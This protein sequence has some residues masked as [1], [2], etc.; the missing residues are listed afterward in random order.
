M[1]NMH[2]DGATQ[3]I[4]VHVVWG[5]AYVRVHAYT[6]S[7]CAF[8]TILLTSLKVDVGILCLGDLA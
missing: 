5:Q 2:I 1:T 4:H 6:Y 8:L 3:H 7:G